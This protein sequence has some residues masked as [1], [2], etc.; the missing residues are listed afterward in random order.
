MSLDS[1]SR[2]NWPFFLIVSAVLHFAILS[3]IVLCSSGQGR[4]DDSEIAAMPDASAGERVQP[5]DT[6]A[7]TDA[8][9]SVDTSL[10]AGGTAASPSSADSGGE[11]QAAAG[12][13]SAISQSG[14][15]KPTASANTINYVVVAGDSLTRIAKR[16]KCTVTELAKLNNI[17]PNSG[18]RIGQR[19]KLPAPAN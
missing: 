10:P 14:N 8:N 4:C 3:L 6:R 2:L 5:A 9:P 12:G 17:K 16:H 15:G 1:I 19:I 7:E 18:L 13:N 11:T